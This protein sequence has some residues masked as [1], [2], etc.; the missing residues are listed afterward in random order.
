MT[1][2][3]MGKNTVL[4]IF[5]HKKDIILE[6]YT[7][8]DK[9]DPMI[10]DLMRKIPVK[11]VSKKTLD[12]MVKSS[13]HQ[14]VLAKI[15]SRNYLNL[16]DFIKKNEEK[17]KSLVLMLDSIF[18]PQNLGAIIRTAECFSVDGV[19]FSKNR[20]SDITPVVSKAS[21]GGT[22]LVNLIKVSNLA[23]A[24][25]VFYDAGYS[26]VAT[27]LEKDS[28]A[29]YDFEFPKKT[30]LIMG[31]EGEG[32]QKILLKKA[33]YKIFIPMQGKLQSLNVSAASAIVLSYIRAQAN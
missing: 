23:N 28:K 9:S 3:L 4:E 19:V 2:F 21:M 17:S 22:E 14:N 26:I 11:F 5:K 18:D 27:T 20:G 8:K 13:S 15:K 1:D 29:L 25:E 31:S 10:L 30:L 24:L 7:A 33:E 12:N 32:V 6:I 16:K